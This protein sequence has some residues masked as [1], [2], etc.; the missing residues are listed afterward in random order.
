MH[1]MGISITQVFSVMLRSKK[2]KI[3]KKMWKLK[4]RW[5]KIKQE[6]HGIETNPSK[7]RAMPEGD[8]PSFWR[9]I[10]KVDFCR[11]SSIHIRILKQV[12][13]HLAVG[14]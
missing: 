14:L 9:R 6:Y 7:N 13:K 10:V 11:D 4:S 5:M 12:P 1:Q 3:Q 2:L 8:N